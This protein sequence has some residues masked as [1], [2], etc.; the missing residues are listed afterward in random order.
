MQ[1][2]EGKLPS[3]LLRELVFDNIKVRNEDVILRPEIGE[4]C[5][6]IEYGDYACVL[7][8]DPITGADKGIGALAVH[9]SCNDVASSGVKPIALLMTI[10]APTGTTKEEIGTIMKEAGEAAAAL[11][12]EIAGG[13]TEITSAVNKVIVST[14]AI[15]KV[16]KHKLVKTAGAQVG[17]DV[18]MTKWA[19]LEGTAILAGDREDELKSLLSPEE[20]KRAQ[21]LS[22]QISVVAEGVL[23]GEH[24]AN[25]MHDVTEGGILGAV[26]EVAE[27]SGTGIEVLIDK[28]PILQ[29]TKKICEHYGINPYRLIS[30][31]SM[32]ITCKD[33]RGLIEKLKAIG[34]QAEIIGKITAEDRYVIEQGAKKELQPPGADELFKA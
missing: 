11:G 16:L 10:M 24:G 34:V 33:G 12:V 29:E 17:D 23:A 21:S 3:E 6:A 18:V 27:S 7:S 9:I 13:H 32:V 8:T 28:I 25:S 2:Q 31:G 22:E 20:L 30:S 5:T 4:D 15:G 26:W 1:M 14:T 19:G